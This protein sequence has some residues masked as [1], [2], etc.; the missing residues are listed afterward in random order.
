LYQIYE[1][2]RGLG[3]VPAGIARSLTFLLH[4]FQFFNLVTIRQ[5]QWFS[6]FIN[7]FLS[8]KAKF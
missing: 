5:F 2:N 4:I 8:Q 1:V 7:G 3:C 6:R